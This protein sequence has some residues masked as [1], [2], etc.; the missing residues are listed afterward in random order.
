M[1]K[2]HDAL[3]KAQL[4][5]SALPQEP[6][7]SIAGPMPEAEG[8]IT[9]PAAASQPQKQGPAT[10][11]PESPEIRNEPPLVL[12]SAAP[13]LLPTE[14][15]KKETVR[16][17]SLDEL[18]RQEELDSHCTKVTW[19]LDPNRI[20]FCD[21]NSAAL[22]AEQFRTLRA[23]LLRI[24]DHQTIRVIQVTSA[25]SAEGKTFVA[26]N[27]AQA[28]A[29]QDSRRV[30]LIDGDL[31]NPG[32]H[33]PIG[34]PLALG[35]SDYL[36]GEA[37]ELQIVQHGQEGGLYFISAGNSVSNPSELLSNGSMKVLLERLAPLFDWVIFDSPPCLPVADAGLISAVCDG[38]LLVVRAA[39]TPSELSQKARQEL[40]G[41]N[42]IGVV[43]NAVDK[44]ETYQAY[45]G[46]GHKNY[47]RGY[48]ESKESGEVRA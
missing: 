13:V 11:E 10:I 8:D 29:R 36:R 9:G 30:L 47:N 31:R 7:P 2:I 28:L 32:L 25:V 17:K 20:V 4:D 43:L 21:G 44:A 37:K 15:T 23:R 48:G 45:Y 16:G 40:Q 12:G 41:R 3:K 1:S 19:H 38:V 34:A 42:V 24:R 26:S 22:G 33:L 5:R 27:L 46:Y 39:S 14:L 35:L 6:K 18:L